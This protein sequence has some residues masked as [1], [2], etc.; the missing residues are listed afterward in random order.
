MPAV[1]AVIAVSAIVTGRVQGVG[2]RY[3]TLRE[4]QQRGLTGWVRNLSDGRVEVLALGP[5]VAVNDLVAWLA[6]GPRLASVT[7]VEVIPVEPD[8]GLSTF[9]VRF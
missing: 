5:S 6:E 7:N 2:F 8:P 9:Q 3:A 4:A 1:P